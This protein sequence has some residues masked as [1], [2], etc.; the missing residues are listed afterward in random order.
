MIKN[1]KD[2]AHRHLVRSGNSIRLEEGTAGLARDPRTDPAHLGPDREYGENGSRAAFDRRRVLRRSAA[3]RRPRW[4]AREIILTESQFQKAFAGAAIENASQG[5]GPSPGDAGKSPRVREGFVCAPNEAA[6]RTRGG[7]EGRILPCRLIGGGA[8]GRSH[9]KSDDLATH[10]DLDPRAPDALRVKPSSALKQAAEAGLTSATTCCT[11][12]PSSR[13][14]KQKNFRCW[15]STAETRQRRHAHHVVGPALQK[16]RSSHSG[17]EEAEH[18]RR[19]RQAAWLRPT[20][21][22]IGQST[23][24]TATNARRQVS[25][26]RFRYR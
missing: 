12:P 21:Y 16:P 26:T 24:S 13:G 11:R 8:S 7:A 1:H 20:G 23:C 15:C 5:N 22:L 19:G 25:T 2:A 4:L 3:S 6:S 9:R 17:Q 18:H 14:C 10:H